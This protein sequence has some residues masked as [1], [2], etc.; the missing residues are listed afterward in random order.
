MT[1][2]EYQFEGQSI[3]PL[4]VET[5][6]GHFQGMIIVVPG[7]NE[8]GEPDRICVPDTSTSYSLALDEAKAL[9]HKLFADKALYF[10]RDNS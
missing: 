5:D 8:S 6:D 4:V 7:S 10:R 9:A 1:H 2:L 3:K